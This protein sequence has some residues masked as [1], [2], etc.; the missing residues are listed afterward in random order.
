[1]GKLSKIRI[2]TAAISAV[3]GLSLVAL[4]LA[5]FFV[6]H[7]PSELSV[8]VMSDTH[9]MAEEQIGGSSEDFARYTW[10]GQ[11]MVHLSEAIFKTSIDTCIA[12]DND[13]LLIS[14]DLTDDGGKKSH[15]SVAAEL[16][17]YEASGKKAF[18]IAGNHDIRN[19][20]HSFV[21]GIEETTENIDDAEFAEIYADFGYDEALSRHENSLSYT[22]DL[23]KKYRLIAIDCSYYEISTD[24]GYVAG[25]HSPNMTDE[26]LSWCTNAVKKAVEDG[27]TP[28]GMIHFPVLAHLGQF[29]DKTLGS[30]NSLVNDNEKVADALLESGLNILFTGHL[31]SQDI[32]SYTKDGNTLYDIETASLTNF[33]MPIRSFKAYNNSFYIST[34]SLSSV[35][36]SYLP[37]HLSQAEKT[38]VTKDFYKFASD[39]VDESMRHKITGKFDE[40][41]IKSLLRQLSIDNSTPEAALLAEDI[42]SN[43]IQDVLDMPIYGAETQSVE[44]ICSQYGVQLPLTEYNTVWELFMF[45]LKANYRGNE[46]ITAD[47]AQGRLVKYSLYSAIYY[48]VDYDLFGKLGE[49]QPELSA[50][51]LESSMQALFVEGKLSLISSNLLEGLL[52]SLRLL[53]SGSLSFLS[54]A[55]GTAAL[56]AIKILIQSGALFGYRLDPYIDADGLLLGELIDGFLF[57]ELAAD[58]L[59][60]QGPYDNDLTISRKDWTYS[61]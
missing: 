15:L 39:F 50:V 36:Q 27:K 32:T 21:N 40:N 58:T 12:D 33:P 3:V 9:V 54:E 29:V 17:R 57:G 23:N 8:S 2:I 43:L 30:E 49:L 59:I 31:H 60:D 19:R 7:K 28:V 14:G 35:K 45:L 1:M 11:K 53:Q 26:L 38:A 42:Y 6:K 46:A 47:S 4:P 34:E 24:D 51:D 37:S 13:F 48:M 41:T 55:N 61:R 10:G 52:H 5:V 16:S 44:S 25:R 18:V 20:S 22:A 56:N